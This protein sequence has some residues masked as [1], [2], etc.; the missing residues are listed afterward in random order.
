MV[1]LAS[2]MGIGK[3]TTVASILGSLLSRGVS[4]S[5]METIVENPETPILKKKVLVL[6]QRVEDAQRLEASIFKAS[7]NDRSFLMLGRSSDPASSFYCP[8]YASVE[9]AGQNRQNPSCDCVQGADLPCAYVKRERELMARLKQCSGCVVV[10]THA[11][12]INDGYK[13]IK[14]D[15]VIIDESIFET[16]LFEMVQV[17]DDDVK[18]LYE[19][20]NQ[21]KFAACKNDGLLLPFLQ[22]VQGVLATSASL[23]GS[24]QTLDFRDFWPTVYTGDDS[25]LLRLMSAKE[26][27]AE[28]R[29]PSLPVE[30]NHKIK[31]FVCDLIRE[32]LNPQKDIQVNQKGILFCRARSALGDLRNMEVINLDATPN[33]PLLRDVFDHVEIHG[34]GFNLSNIDIFQVTGR[35]Y[36]RSV[37]KNH[38]DRRR[39][40]EQIVGYLIEKHKVKAPLLVVPKPL[41]APHSDGPKTN[42]GAYIT[43]SHPNLETIYYGGETK[44]SNRFQDRDSIF[45]VG[46]HQQPPSIT[47]LWVN[48]IRRSVPITGE[49]TKLLKPMELV[50][51]SETI[52]AR[53]QAAHPDPL[54]QATIDHFISSQVIQA[55]GRLRSISRPG[56]GLRAFIVN[57]TILEGIP[58]DEALPVDELLKVLSLKKSR[59]KPRKLAKQENAE[60]MRIIEILSEHVMYEPYLGRNELSQRT[61]L[62][63][64]TVSKYL[65]SIQ[66]EVNLGTCQEQ[67]YLL[68]GTREPQMIRER[69][70]MNL[71]LVNLYM[72]FGLIDFDSFIGFQCVTAR[73]T[74]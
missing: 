2:A 7:R 46:L 1:I 47:E 20:L 44:G 64:G 3:T 40:L 73:Q 38:A 66:R 29:F 12:F 30:R 21:P 16:N 19:R 32:I 15:T 14:F 24:E 55:I 58:V 37:L 41:Y 49:A 42:Q 4:D 9:K 34:Q 11:S 31:R 60:R 45:L 61:G 33:E 23:T 39:E 17:T 28:S 52:P 56:K 62:S 18:A 53:L 67:T 74:A 10:S 63:R 25:D 48:A 51:D 70:L 54:I 26:N 43:V 59:K 27:H 69:V 36:S 72:E 5:C 35:V 65:S 71:M 68:M 57:G 13:L 22:A 8:D 6:T 50:G